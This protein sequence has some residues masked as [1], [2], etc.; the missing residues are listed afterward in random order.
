MSLQQIDDLV[1]LIQGLRLADA[2]SLRRCRA[3]LPVAAGTEEFLKLLER[4]ELLTPFQ[5]DRLKKGETE[6]LVLGDYKLLYRNASGTFARVFRACSIKDN[7]MIGLKVL[8]D[9]WTG[10]ADMVRLF[11]REGQIGQRLKHRNIVPIH[12]VATE[13]RF[14]YLTMEF[15][16]GGNLRDFLKIRGQLSPAEACRYTLDIALAL[17]YAL[18]LG[19]THRDMKMTN[20]L[21]SSQGIA[22][23]IDFGLAVN[24]SLLNRLGTSDLQQAVEYTTLER[25][26]DAPPN[27]PRS[28]LFFLGVIV[29]ELLTGTP[30]YPRTRDVQ[31]RKQFRRYRD[32]RPLS[33]LAPDI[34]R[35]VV[36]LVERLMHINPAER[37]Q[38]PAELIAEL[39][40]TLGDLGEPHQSGNGQPASSEPTVM[41]VEHRPK[42]Q[43]LLRNYLSRHGYRVLLLSDVD[44]ALDRVRRNPPDC[45]LLMG[46]SI[47]DRVVEDFQRALTISRDRSLVSV[48]VLGEQQSQLEEMVPHTPAGARILKQPLKLRELRETIANE[49][50]GRNQSA[51]GA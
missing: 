8:R 31:E 49:M 13:G 35:R 5:A 16:E 32:V 20:V 26:S 27:D 2:D 40:V 39:H 51:G 34:P 14:H 18:G 37:F 22:K 7:S 44:R 12:D 43:D 33:S 6:G 48:L 45:L 50:H 28:D 17:D 19:I 29:Y 10:D 30:A 36:D 41:C 47:G 21:M 3:D 38:S 9:R 1:Q 11:H 15:V 46:D 42:Q 25:G 23:L 4:R 24:D